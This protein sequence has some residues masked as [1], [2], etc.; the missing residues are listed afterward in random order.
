MTRRASIL[1]LALAAGT[2]AGL[3]QG[4]DYRATVAALVAVESGGDCLR[5]GDHGRAVGCLQMWPCAVRE[6]NR[7]AG[8]RVWTLADRADQ[9][10]AQRM[11]VTLL[12]WQD[13]RTGGR[14]TDVELACR[15]RN[16]GG[17]VCAWYRAK[18]EK[19]LKKGRK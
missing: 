6:A 11:A 10:E 3:A 1:A 13:L 18:V 8:R 9:W 2:L 19:Q 16:P 7:L 15:W 14:L 17:R 4:R 5:K 12:R